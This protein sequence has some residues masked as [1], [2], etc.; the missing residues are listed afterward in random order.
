MTG[1]MDPVFQL[2][3]DAGR[4]LPSSRTRTG[5]MGPTTFKWFQEK[6]ETERERERERCS[7]FG[8]Y[9]YIYIYVYIFLYIKYCCL[10]DYMC[11]PEYIILYIYIYIYIRNLFQDA[12]PGHD[13]CRRG[14]NLPSGSPEMEMRIVEPVACC[15]SD[16][17]GRNKTHTCWLFI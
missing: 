8:I 2:T 6:R 11:I 1:M 17:I 10:Y 15:G 16:C 4:G 5:M 7:H 13:P 9:I 14:R 12:S 3:T